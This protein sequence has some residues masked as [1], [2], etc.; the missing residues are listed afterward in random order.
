MRTFRLNK[1]V[2]DSIVPYMQDLG[3]KVVFHKLNDDEY[4]AEL[5]NKLVEEAREFD[6]KEPKATKELADVLEVVDALAAELGVS[7][8][9][10]RKLQLQIR[11][12][13]GGFSDR[14]YVE[15]VGV[16]DGDKWGDYYAAEPVRFPEE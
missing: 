2:R 4:L 11:K 9:E 13:R 7:F 6:P 10:L 12:E 3:Q 1:L 14:L 16:P 8:E 5:A 15:K